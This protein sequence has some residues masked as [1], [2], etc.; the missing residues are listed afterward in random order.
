[1]DDDLIYKISKL[2]ALNDSI[3]E[4]HGYNKSYTKK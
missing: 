1:M 4:G 3:G 2:L